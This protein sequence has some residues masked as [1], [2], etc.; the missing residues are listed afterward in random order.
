MEN[1]QKLEMWNYITLSPILYAH[2]LAN[3][4][5][6]A[7]KAIGFLRSTF[8]GIKPTTSIQLS[9]SFVIPI[10]EYGLCICPF[11]KKLKSWNDEILK[12]SIKFF[13]F[14][15]SIGFKR[16]NKG[17]LLA[18]TRMLPIEIKEQNYYKYKRNGK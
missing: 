5:E 2:S 15:S 11:P 4:L 9:K 13:L 18:I 14:K 7:M 3:T 10:I 6:K 17:K 16:V 12:S 8:T 1:Y